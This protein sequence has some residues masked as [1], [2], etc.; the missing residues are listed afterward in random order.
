[1]RA[2]NAWPQNAVLAGGRQGCS[3]AHRRT[4]RSTLT[5][6]AAP[7]QP[8][9]DPVQERLDPRS[10][11]LPSPFPRSRGRFPP[12]LGPSLPASVFVA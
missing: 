11:V 10:N 5:N 1:M 6:G 8:R 9:A 4:A 3:L 7:Q 12:R 2:R